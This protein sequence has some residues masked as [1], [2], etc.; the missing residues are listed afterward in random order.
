MDRFQAVNKSAELCRQVREGAG[1]DGG[2]CLDFHTELDMP[3]AVALANI[4]EP[5][6]PYFVED[7]VVVKIPPSTKPCGVRCASPSPSE[8][9]L[10]L[11]GNGTS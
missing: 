6:R 8:N 4:I 3:D 1:K 11:S 10:A 7:L 5:L 2:W 9:S